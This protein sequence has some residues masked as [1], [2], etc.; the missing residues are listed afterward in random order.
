MATGRSTP[1][2]IGDVIEQV[3]DLFR[4]EMR[5]FRAEI[6]QKISQATH[7]IIFVAVGALLLIAALFVWLGAAVDGLAAVGLQRYW[8]GL[9]VGAVVAVVGAIFLVRAVNNLKPANLKPRRSIEQIQ[10]T[11]AVVKA[12]VK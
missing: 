9:I 7:A 6:D 11:A 5:L 12:Q 10:K 8:A 4:T 3:T 2:L 1:S